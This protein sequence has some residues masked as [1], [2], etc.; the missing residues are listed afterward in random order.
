MLQESRKMRN[1]RYAL[2]VGDIFYGLI[3]KKIVI[4]DGTG[5]VNFYDFPELLL[6]LAIESQDKQER[7][8]STHV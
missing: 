2:W 8:L 6:P 4:L 1:I 3:F 7:C 5:S